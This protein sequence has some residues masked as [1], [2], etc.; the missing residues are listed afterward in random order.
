MIAHTWT[1]ESIARFYCKLA[2]NLVSMLLGTCVTFVV[3]DDINGTYYSQA[4]YY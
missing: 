4:I 3:Y 2:T 1:R